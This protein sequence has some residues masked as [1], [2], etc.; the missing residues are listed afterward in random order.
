MASNSQLFLKH[1]DETGL[2]WIQYQ[3]HK[4]MAKKENQNELRTFMQSLPMSDYNEI[5]KRIIS[6]CYISYSVWHNW[7]N[8][9]TVIPPLAKSV[10]ND[11]TGYE[12]FKL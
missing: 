2:I 11:I 12:V 5:R 7:M 4:N 1:W 3:K 9:I 6:E 8:G 10:I